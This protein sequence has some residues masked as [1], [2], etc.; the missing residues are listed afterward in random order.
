MALLEDIKVLFDADTL[1]EVFEVKNSSKIE[2]IKKAY[3]KKSLLCHPDKAKQEDKEEATRKFQVLCK[4]YDILSDEEKRKI[5]DDCGS[6]DEESFDKN[7]DWMDYWRNLF[8]KVTGKMIDD[9]MEK[10]HGSEKEKDDLKNCY[11]KCKGDMNKIPEYFLGY[12]YEQ[13]D[14]IVGMIN[15]LI[16]ANEVPA[17]KAFTNES[18][19]SKEKRRKKFAREAKEAKKAQEDMGDLASMITKRR[20]QEGA[21]FL[22]ALEA[23]YAPKTKRSRLLD[24]APPPAKRSRRATRNN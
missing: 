14:R 8:P 9:F 5:Y 22:A 10:F 16:E 17:Y 7:M 18:V 1:Y 2:E 3:R 19:A 6:V 4:C 21:D 15:D 24:E 13:E 20:S 11:L 12:H 23:K